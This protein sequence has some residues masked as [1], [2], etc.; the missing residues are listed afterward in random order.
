MEFT[1]FTGLMYLKK[2]FGKVSNADI[3][4]SR[5]ISPI[6]EVMKMTKIFDPGCTGYILGQLAFSYSLAYCTFDFFLLV[7]AEIKFT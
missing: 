4:L 6:S 5:R 1:Y 7:A 3:N 2:M